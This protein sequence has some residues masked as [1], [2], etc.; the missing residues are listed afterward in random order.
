MLY[1]H[2]QDFDLLC[3]AHFTQEIFKTGTECAQKLKELYGCSQNVISEH[4]FF[5]SKQLAYVASG[6]VN[7]V[8]LLFLPSG[9]TVL[10]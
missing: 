5:Y 4:F 1:E 6:G 7:R 3:N 8:I 9:K 2:V 10:M